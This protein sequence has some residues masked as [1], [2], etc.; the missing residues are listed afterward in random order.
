MLTFRRF[1]LMLTFFER[2][3]W[4]AAD[5]ALVDAGREGE[6]A[7][8]RARIVLLLVLIASPVAT[9]LRLPGE[10]PA[11]I[12]V[13]MAGVF[14]GVSLWLL[15]LADRR[16]HRPWLG[17]ATAAA[18]V[19]FVSVYHAFIFSSGFP[20]MALGSRATFALY[21]VGVTAT[22]LRQDRRITT[23]TG[24]LAAAQWL[25]LMAWARATGTADAAVAAGRFYGDT[26]LVGQAEE[27]ILIAVATMLARMI[28]GRAGAMRL[29]SVR[30]GLT[31]L[32][33][34]GH[35][36]ERLATELIRSARQ[37]RPLT[38]AVIDL[39]GFKR[40]NDT[41]GHPAG[42]LVLREVGT[43][44]MTGVRRTDLSARIGGD[45]FALVFV[46]TSVADAAAKLE[47]IRAAVAAQIVRLRND[48]G[49]S[50]TLSA[51]VAVAPDDATDAET[52]VAV[53]DR[54]LLQAK[55]LGR[56]R[57]VASDTA[58]APAQARKRP[59]GSWNI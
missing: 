52:L 46:D 38:L 35:F 57:L 25:L 23:C 19:T 16:E 22:S 1:P 27:V 41:H 43:R 53:A 40:V 13:V 47:E 9:L 50:V 5:P 59:E 11:L 7:V 37:K 34:R 54:R 48:S 21:L 17:F 39:D 8:A 2:D 14:L 20:D 44:L 3:L 28:V 30:D 6:A 49:V 51:G 45:E 56:N 29:S 4:P 10:R 58:V 36:E 55:Q 18:D 15:R 24:L 12:A 33:S 32:L 42:D 31:G 26:S